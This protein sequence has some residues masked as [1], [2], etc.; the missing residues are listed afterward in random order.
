VLDLYKQIN[1][2]TKEDLNTKRGALQKQGVAA[3]QLIDQG[4]PHQSKHGMSPMANT[5][6]LRTST[7]LL[8]NK[9]PTV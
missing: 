2:S 7:N 9:V 8:T 1:V 6:D 4:K 5:Y 3:G